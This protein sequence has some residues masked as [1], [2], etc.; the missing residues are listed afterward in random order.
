MHRLAFCAAFGVAVLLALPAQPQTKTA[1]AQPAAKQPAAAPTPQPQ[2]LGGAQ[3]WTAYSAPEKG[4]QICYVVGEPSKSEPQGVKR[5]PVHLL[6]THNTADK[7]SGVVSFVAGYGFKDGSAA[8]LDVGG[9]KFSLFTKDDTAWARDSATDKA[10]V[11]AMLKAKQAV[12]KGGSA[13]G[14]ATTDTYVL[15]GFS[16]VLGEIDKACKVKR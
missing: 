8:E 5:D 3:S 15:T 2:K 7:T 12:I 10:I 1:P 16:Q 9:K 11:E 6:V 4:G 13:R 14:T